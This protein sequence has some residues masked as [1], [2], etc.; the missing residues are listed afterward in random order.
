MDHI[1][2]NSALSPP[3]RFLSPPS[4]R[5]PPHSFSFPIPTIPQVSLLMPSICLGSSDEDVG[6]DCVLFVPK[7]SRKSR[8]KHCK[9]PQTSHSDSPA[10]QSHEHVALA[11][12]QQDHN[13][14]VD[15]LAKS[16]KAS[17][18]HDKARRETLQ[19]FRP[20]PLALVSPSPIY[21]T[22]C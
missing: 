8:C 7:R 13:K 12:T 17:A 15:R 19:G 16:L 3:H 6:C 22:T 20:T 21:S 18:V 1:K 10:T 9:H 5:L 2:L 11:A 4:Q 14:Y